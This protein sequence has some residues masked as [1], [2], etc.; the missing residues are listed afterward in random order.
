MD[1]FGFKFTGFISAPFDGIYTFYLVSEDGSRL[2]IGDQLVVDNDGLH[3][4]AEKS[5]QAALKSGK[6]AISVMYFE[7]KFGEER[8][9]VYYSVRGAG[10]QLIPAN[11]LYRRQ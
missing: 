5:G 10:K 8:L 3:H 2:Y 11:M 9:E 6:H 7:A 1:D 4:A